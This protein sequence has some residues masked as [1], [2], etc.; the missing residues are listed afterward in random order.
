MISPAAPPRPAPRGFASS[1]KCRANGNRRGAGIPSH[2]TS[3]R[4]ER[5]LEAQRHG[6]TRQE[7]AAAIPTT[8]AWGQSGGAAAPHGRRGFRSLRSPAAAGATN[9]P[10]AADADAATASGGGT[11]SAAA[12]ARLGHAPA[13]GLPF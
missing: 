10:S 11:G 13:G 12:G 8:K 6:V 4:R 5:A 9:G 3:N 2:S 1:R 7:R